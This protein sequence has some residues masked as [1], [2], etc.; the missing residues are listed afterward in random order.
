MFRD[1]ISV[2]NT[3]CVFQFIFLFF[4]GNKNV[5]FFYFKHRRRRHRHRHRHRHIG[6]L[7][8]QNSA[9]SRSRFVFFGRTEQ[10]QVDDVSVYQL[11]NTGNFILHIFVESKPECKFILDGFFCCCCSIG[12]FM[13]CIHA[14]FTFTPYLDNISHSNTL[15]TFAIRTT[16]HKVAHSF[17]YNIINN[18]KWNAHPHLST[19]T[20][21]QIYI[22]LTVANLLFS[23]SCLLD[24]IFIRSFYLFF[25]LCG[26]LRSDF[27]EYVSYSPIVVYVC[28]LHSLAFSLRLPLSPSHSLF[29]SLFLSITFIFP[30]DIHDLRE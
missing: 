15:S 13:P 14:Y 24:S 27:Q 3:V 4:G 21:T 25:L 30:A 7:Y 6:M 5:D 16:N 12:W 2:L 22:L 29:L 23:Y 9:C 19:G 26:V 17:W 28:S 20:W 8:L 18:N 1:N 10:S 11:C